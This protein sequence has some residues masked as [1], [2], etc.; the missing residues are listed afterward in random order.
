MHF[1]KKC[2][3]PDGDLQSTNLTQS[4]LE[5]AE[6]LS[7]IVKLSVFVSLRT[8]KFRVEAPNGYEKLLETV[9]KSGKSVDDLDEKE[10]EELIDENLYENISSQKLGNSGIILQHLIYE[11]HQDE[12]VRQ[13]FKEFLINTKDI[14]KIKSVEYLESKT[15]KKMIR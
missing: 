11:A 14:A 4:Q 5:Y 6:V 13:M 10:L 1:D 2:R 15:G 3:M 8:A 12:Q 9:K 7:Q